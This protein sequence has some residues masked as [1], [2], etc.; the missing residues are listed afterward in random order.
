MNPYLP[1][2][3]E[4][5]ERIQESPTLF[6]LRLRLTDAQRQQQYQFEPGQFN[7]L[8]LPNVGEI[9]ISIV[10]DP[11]D[12]HILDHTIRSVG[13]IS[14]GL[15]QL[16]Q[17]DR[18]GIRG[19]FGRGWPLLSAEQ[20]DVIVVTGGLGCAPV[21]AAIN[22]IMYRRERFGTVNIIQGVKHSNDFIWKERYDEWRAAPDTVVLLAA[23]QGEA[24]WPWHIGPVTKLF[25][26]LVFAKEHV[27]AMMC[28]PEGMMRAAITHLQEQGMADAD[29]WLSMERNM[30]CAVGHCGHCQYGNRFVCK[31]GPVFCYEEIKS[32][33]GQR[34]F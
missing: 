33:F 3:A 34:G 1:Q 16:K 28:G 10:S 17:G 18:I 13:R 15:E 4:I 30:Q 14:R 32:L 6:T 26:Q 8:Y 24:I 27:I 29:I 20:K 21:V 7:M 12:E 2:E 5:I 22:Y 19:P 11:K 9:P 25:D 31:D 23:D